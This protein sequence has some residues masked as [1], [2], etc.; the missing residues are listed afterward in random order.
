M[1]GKQTKLRKKL[2]KQEIALLT[3]STNLSKEQ[4]I[5]WHQEFIAQYP[6]GK[7]NLKQFT[8]T[9]GTLFG[10]NDNQTVG[11]GK[12]EKF[13]KIVF[14]AFDTNRNNEIEFNEFM[15]AIC[16]LSETSWEQ[17]LHSAFKIYDLDQ[18]NKIDIHELKKI[19]EALYDLKSVPESLRIGNNSPDTKARLIFK[20]LDSDNDNYLSEDEFVTGLLNN[21]DFVSLLL[22]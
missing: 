12:P 14:D 21:F 15:L 17:K 7:Q 16:A 3:S 20:S 13:S 10:G 5:T 11:I 8:K 1:G 18:N 22:T 19:I 9:I 6:D 4:I 2:N